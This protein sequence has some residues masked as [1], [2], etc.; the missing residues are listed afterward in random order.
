MSNV[1]RITIIVALIAAIATVALLKHKRSQQNSPIAQRSVSV[2]DPNQA[3]LK[4]PKL[5]DLGSDKCV[6]CKM[7]K[8]ILD[9][10]KT[11]YAGK[12][13]VIFM[14]V[15]ENPEISNQYKIESIPTQIFYDAQGKELFRHEGFMPKEDI[16]AKFKELGINLEK[17][18]ASVK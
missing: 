8:P 9:D 5:V 16:F 17:E 10:L 12:L 4:L 3:T 1:L 15:W 13:E 11:N 18:Q 6:P 2:K 7:M 14:D